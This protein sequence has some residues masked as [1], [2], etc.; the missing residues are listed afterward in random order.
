MTE[1]VRK[2]LRHGDKIIVT[3]K[4]SPIMGTNKS[5]YISNLQGRIGVIADKNFENKCPEHAH[6]SFNVYFGGNVWG[7]LTAYCCNKIVE[8]NDGFMRVLH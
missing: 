7:S 6:T 1:K 4:I 3:K 2:T 8:D 5:I